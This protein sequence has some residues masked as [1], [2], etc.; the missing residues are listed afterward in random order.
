MKSSPEDIATKVCRAVELEK[1]LALDE[2]NTGN[3]IPCGKLVNFLRVGQFEE[4]VFL[5]LM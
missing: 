1:G 5:I 3:F 2:P 4:I